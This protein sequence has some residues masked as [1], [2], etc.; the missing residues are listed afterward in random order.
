MAEILPFRALR[1]D[2][3]RVSLTEVLTQPYDKIT[4]AMQDNYYARSPHNLV[5]FELGKSEPGDG[6][7]NNVYTR[8]RDFVAKQEEAGVMALD[9]KPAIY[10]YSQRFENPV[11]PGE[12]LERRGF[13][14]LGKLHEY[15][16]GVVHRHELTHS[17]AKTDRMNVLA[18][19]RTHSGQI[20]MLYE[21]PTQAIDSALW[22]AVGTLQPEA[23]VVDEY[24][25]ENR[26]WPV[27]DATVIAAVTGGMKDKR[28]IIADGHHRYETALQYR[29]NQG[30][31]NGS[32]PQ[33]YVM[34]T[35]VNM[36]APGLIVLPTHR[37]IYGL[38][39]FDTATLLAKLESCFEVRAVDSEMDAG[40]VLPELARA[41]ENAT[42]IALVTSSGAYILSA[43]KS[44][45]EQALAEEHPLRRALDVV[46]LHK[47]I[48]ER[49]LG[50]SEEAIREQRNIRYYRSAN[51]AVSDAQAGANAAFLLSPASVVVMRDLSYSS[52]VMPQ[53]STDF[54][55]KLLSGLALYNLDKSFAK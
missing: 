16:E 23:S 54:Y 15:S 46:V 4:P 32:S 5:R 8:A 9:S 44:A 37:V 49:L 14:A 33:D 1:Y 42:S 11:Q 18:T 25:V 40:K 13:I 45:V 38:D 30:S 34:M 21:D 26:L 19:T 47:L 31:Q 35:F 36:S 17:K 29:N 10:A 51:E 43:R 39:N 7:A 20:F 53:K 22:N 3:H 24:G 27:T 41:A 48:I 6:D 28:L 2:T 55:P 50:L 52:N 12:W